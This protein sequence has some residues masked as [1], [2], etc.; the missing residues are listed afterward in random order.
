MSSINDNILPTTSKRYEEALEKHLKN[1][2]YELDVQLKELIL[3]DSIK[4][5]EQGNLEIRD[6]W[7]G[8]IKKMNKS[9]PLENEK[10][11]P[12]LSDTKLNPFQKEVT[13]L[14]LKQISQQAL[15]EKKESLNNILHEKLKHLK[16]K[17]ERKNLSD[18]KKLL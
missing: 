9:E 12:Q 3:K 15:I 4:T 7:E 13:D 1:V 18:I 6:H 8:L 10:L 14:Q 11:G 5:Y 16:E 17:Q 2:N